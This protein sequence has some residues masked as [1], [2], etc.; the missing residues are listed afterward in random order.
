MLTLTFFSGDPDY[1]LAF[2]TRPEFGAGW[3]EVCLNPK[4]Y[5]LRE[6]ELPPPEA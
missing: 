3:T 6:A 2:N 4:P 1:V 5:A